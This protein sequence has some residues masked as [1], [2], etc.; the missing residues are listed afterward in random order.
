[1][2]LFITCMPGIEMLLGDELAKLGFSDTVTGYGGVRVK[3][4][5]IEAVYRINYFSRLASRVLLPLS[6]FRC[7]DAK[8]LYSG[9][10][11]VDWTGYFP[12][13]KPK[14]TFAID[15]NVSHPMLRNSLF[16]AQV[17]KD[18]LCDQLVQKSGWRPSVNLKEP[19]L[20]L[21]LFIQQGSA[22]ISI[23]TSGQPLHKRGYRQESVEAPMQENLAA[24]LLA[25]AHFEG[26]EIACDPC[27]GSGTLLIE[28][29]L[30]ASKTP[31][32][33]LRKKW[34]FFNLPDFSEKNW[35]VFKGE[36]D[37]RRT[38][39]PK[40]HIFGADL[41]KQ[42]VHAAKVNLRVAGFHQSVEIAQSDLRD[43]EPP[44]PPNFVIC[45]PPYGR[46]LQDENSL[47]PLY[48]ALGDFMK[49]KTS[50]PAKGYLF[51]GSL[52][53]SKQV[54]LSAERRHLVN[55]GG[56]ESRLLEFDLYA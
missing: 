40:K 45:N 26:E 55:H 33:F 23:D 18:A 37:Q 41:N 50:K 44:A 19:D 8:A 52:E 1:M 9:I 28:A 43:Y 32:G 16:A 31:P 5:S 54:G 46:R 34:G 17:V 10:R 56:I 2:D 39:L 42:A 21:N 6:R 29:A 22:V 53:L 7:Q 24:A 30:I 25:L 13:N 36:A 12:S 14:A 49:R 35:L 15:A 38:A 48:R 47:V 51:T 27:C 20:Q 3:E 4:S 11:R